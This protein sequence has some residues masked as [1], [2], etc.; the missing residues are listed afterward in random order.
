[1]KQAAGSAGL[2]HAPVPVCMHTSE[3]KVYY[4]WVALAYMNIDICEDIPVCSLY[5]DVLQRCYRWRE[6]DI[7]VSSPNIYFHL[8]TDDHS[9]EILRCF[10]NPSP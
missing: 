6:C 3:A 1:M 9:K 5:G 4:R 8:F 2:S 7:K 10:L